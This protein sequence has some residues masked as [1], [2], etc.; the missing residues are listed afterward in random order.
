MIIMP[1]FKLERLSIRYIEQVI[2]EYAFIV[3]ILFLFL[4]HAFDAPVYANWHVLGIKSWGVFMMFVASLHF[5]ALW[6]NGRNQLYSR[7][8]RLVACSGHL[9]VSLTFGYYFFDQGA[10][11]G[12]VLFLQLIPRLI[13]PVLFRV[14]G[15][16]KGIKE[17]LND[18]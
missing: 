2:A 15:E 12:C 16:A 7:A 8:L 14:T 6:Y 11:W 4:P 13:I 5:L 10:I 18:D 3:S 9:M 17:G 1:T